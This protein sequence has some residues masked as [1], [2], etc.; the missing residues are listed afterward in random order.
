MEHV[1]GE[2]CLGDVH[3]MLPEQVLYIKERYGKNVTLTVSKV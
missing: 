2:N 3:D 1:C